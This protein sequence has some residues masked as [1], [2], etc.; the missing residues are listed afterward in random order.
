MKKTINELY[1]QVEDLR[2]EIV[3]LKLEAKVNPP[4][5]SNLLIKKRKA[6]ARLLTKLAQN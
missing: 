5:D 6:L 3:K 4:K 1:K 2:R